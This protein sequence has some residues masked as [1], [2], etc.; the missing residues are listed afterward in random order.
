MLTEVKEK[1][2]LTPIAFSSTSADPASTWRA[3]YT[4]FKQQNG[5]FLKGDKLSFEDMPNQG[6]KSLQTIVE[7]AEA[8]FL[9]RTPPTLRW[10]LC[11]APGVAR[12]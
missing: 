2:R 8:G 9:P 11:S 4:F 5:D 3:W 12:S 6:K 10:S 7:L 1:A